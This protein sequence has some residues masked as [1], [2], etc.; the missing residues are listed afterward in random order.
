M[1]VLCS[2]LHY[3]LL[4]DTIIIIVIMMRPTTAV[5]SYEINTF[6]VSHWPGLKRVIHILRDVEDAIGA[7]MGAL[8]KTLLKALIRHCKGTFKALLRHFL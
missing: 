4:L 5:N 2:H 7:S 1:H 3:M 8:V 6:V